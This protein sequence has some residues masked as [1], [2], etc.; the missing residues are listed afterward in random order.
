MSKII[1]GVALLALAGGAYYVY[2]KRRQNMKDWYV[3][4]VETVEGRLPF[5]SIVSFFKTLNLDQKTHIPFIGREGG[6]DI[7]RFFGS[8]PFPKH[9]EGYCAIFIGV[10]NE[11]SQNIDN[12]KVIYAKDFDEKINEVFGNEYFVVLS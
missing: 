6:K 2:H 4:N 9:K 12:F 10:F 1:I 11:K 7:S 5:D 3:S 8:K